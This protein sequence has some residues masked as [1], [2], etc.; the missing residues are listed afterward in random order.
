MA[1]W[2]KHKDKNGKRVVLFTLVGDMTDFAGHA[3]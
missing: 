2:I 1:G 3:K